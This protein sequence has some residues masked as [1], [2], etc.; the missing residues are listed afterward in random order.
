MAR[1]RAISRQLR[2][3]IAHLA[4]RLMVVD[5]IDALSLAKRKAARQVGA[6]QA[7]SLPSN[8]E[9]EA[10][11]EIYLQLY[12]AEEHAERVAHLRACA[13]RL[14]GT[15]ARFNP[16]LSGPV[17]EGNAGRYSNVDLHLFTD[18]PK[19]VEFFMLDQG[20]D[21]KQRHRKIYRGAEPATIVAF[22]VCTKDADFNISVFDYNDLRLGLRSTSNG[23]A[24]RHAGPE[25]VAAMLNQAGKASQSD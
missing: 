17:L 20:F 7:R 19:T 8:E 18:S 24:F 4:A 25:S 12:R 10:A 23:R 1:D 15:L 22:L 5:G 6:T 16:K 11:L 9:V 14:M 13:L 2:S 3:R 21:Y